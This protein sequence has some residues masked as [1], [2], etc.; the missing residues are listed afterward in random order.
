MDKVVVL[1][2]FEPYD[3]FLVNPSWEAVKA[4]GNEKAGLYNVKVFKIPL[5][6]KEIKP[7]ITRIIDDESLGALI[8][9]GQS[10]R[11]VISLEK[12]AINYADLTEAAVLYNCGTRP[13]DEILEPNAPIAYSTKLSI[14]KILNQLRKSNIPAEISYSAGTFGC[15]QL[16]YNMMHKLGSER[17][18][19]PAGFIHVPS[20]PSQ[21]AK[22]QREKNLKLP[23]MNL[24]TTIKAIKIVIE[25][26]LEDI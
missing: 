14:R 11:P 25:T 17:L 15:N 23:S 21:V 22:L 6:Y 18:D 10:Y 8:S 19:I 16:F 20:L 9:F 4:F 2:G 24:E 12:V 26:T 3:D 7:T 5:I 13:K 1:T